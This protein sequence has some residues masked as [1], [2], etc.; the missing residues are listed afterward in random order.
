MRMMDWC[1]GRKKLLREE[2]K[3]NFEVGEKGTLGWGRT[4]YREGTIGLWQNIIVWI[5]GLNRLVH[6]LLSF[7]DGKWEA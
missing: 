1:E 3:R 4:W 6:R 2:E 7:E 5:K